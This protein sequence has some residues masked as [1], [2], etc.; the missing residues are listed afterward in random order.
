VT[1]STQVTLLER[2]RDGGDA[3]VWE[4]FFV[5]EVMGSG[6]ILPGRRVG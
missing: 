5:P 6:L 2:F 4:E 1:K 3:A